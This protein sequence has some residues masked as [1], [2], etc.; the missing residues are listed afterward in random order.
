MT[1]L[2]SFKK[3]EKNMA[4]PVAPTNSPSK[5]PQKN[6]SFSSLDF[7]TA[8]LMV[9]WMEVIRFYCNTSHVK[10]CDIFLFFFH[11]IFI[12]SMENRISSKTTSFFLDKMMN[13]ELNHSCWRAKT[14]HHHHH[15]RHHHHHHH[16]H[17]QFKHLEY[18]K[19]GT[20]DIPGAGPM[21]PR[22]LGI[23]DGSQRPL[24]G[25]IHSVTGVTGETRDQRWQT[26]TS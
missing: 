20:C 19:T 7:W 17:I 23:K 3:Q 22:H 8:S 24:S 9:A 6:G 2:N 10:N 16:H 11:N 15:H 14:S 25:E 21:A 18:C 1:L 26:K 5:N 12:G 13:F 4:T